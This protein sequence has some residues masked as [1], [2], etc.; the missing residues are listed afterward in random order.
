MLYIYFNWNLSTVA[1]ERDK[2]RAQQEADP[3]ASGKK[4]NSA[5]LLSWYKSTNTDAREAW[6]SD[7]G[8]DTI[9]QYWDNLPRKVQMLTLDFTGIKVQILTLERRGPQT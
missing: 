9:G 7:L 4:K 2:V 5:Y 8:W 1:A 6:P 3:R